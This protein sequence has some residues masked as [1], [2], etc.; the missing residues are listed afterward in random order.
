ME[1]E[2]SILLPLVNTQLGNFSCILSIYGRDSLSHT[3]FALDS[4]LFANLP[5]SELQNAC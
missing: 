5:T 2:N 4:L 3:H 1:T